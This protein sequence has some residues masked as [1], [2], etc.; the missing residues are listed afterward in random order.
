M[1]RRH[2]PTADGIVVMVEAG[3]GAK[4]VTVHTVEIL[5][6]CGVR[7]QKIN[8]G[9][10]KV[11]DISVPLSNGGMRR[12]S[13]DTSKGVWQPDDKVAVIRSK[14]AFLD[15]INRKVREDI[16]RVRFS[17][18][19]VIEFDSLTGW[20]IEVLLLRLATQLPLETLRRFRNSISVPEEERHRLKDVEK[21]IASRLWEGLASGAGRVAETVKSWFH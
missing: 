6:K 14:E 9:Y 1:Y 3:K 5:L 10:N 13:F 7:P 16:P 19:Q 21:S 4:A 17:M 20:N 11:G 8:F 15:G 18:D 2:A 12:V